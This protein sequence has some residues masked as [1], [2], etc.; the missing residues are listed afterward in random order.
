M[1]PKPPS[2]LP[3]TTNI[4]LPIRLSPVKVSKRFSND[5]TSSAW[6]PMPLPSKCQPPE[7]HGPFPAWAGRLTGRR[8]LTPSGTGGFARVFPCSPLPRVGTA[9]A[10]AQKAWLPHLKGGEAPGEGRKAGAQGPQSGPSGMQLGHTPSYCLRHRSRWDSTDQSAQCLEVRPAGV[11]LALT[12]P[13]LLP[14][15]PRHG[16]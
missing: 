12:R 4:L 10:G 2:V 11:P 5:R 13:A 15:F 16:K 14:C 1:S 8:T 3:D 9:R 6:H 7:N